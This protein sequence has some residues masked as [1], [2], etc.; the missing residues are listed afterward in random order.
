MLKQINKTIKDLLF[1][2]KVLETNNLEDT[3][4]YQEIIKKLA[5][6]QAELVAKS[7]NI[8]FQS[9]QIFYNG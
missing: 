4:E 9:N 2:K 5:L 7:T 6:K 1:E 3:E 8:K